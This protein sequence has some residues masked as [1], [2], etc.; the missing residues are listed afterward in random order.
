M[1]RVRKVMRF[2]KQMALKMD[3]GCESYVLFKK[4]INGNQGTTWQCK[5]LYEVTHFYKERWGSVLQRKT[6]C[7]INNFKIKY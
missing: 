1:E 4:G 3:F 7:K 5:L 6:T 2:K